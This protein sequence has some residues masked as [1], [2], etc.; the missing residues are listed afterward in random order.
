MASVFEQSFRQK[1]E[2]NIIPE[3]GKNDSRT[4]KADTQKNRN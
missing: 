3:N 2:K 4:G 1:D